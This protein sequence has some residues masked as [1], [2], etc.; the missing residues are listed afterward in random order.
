MNTDGTTVVPVDYLVGPEGPRV[1]TPCLSGHMIEAI[2]VLRDG[3]HDT[4]SWG[5]DGATLTAERKRHVY[6]VIVQN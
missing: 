4:S 5:W 3:G 2:F 6:G 1:D